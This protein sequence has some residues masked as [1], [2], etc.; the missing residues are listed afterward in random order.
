MNGSRLSFWCLDNEDIELKKSKF[1][2][3]EALFIRHREI[4][5]FHS[6][7]EIDIRLTRAEI[8][9][10]GYSKSDDKRLTVI[11]PTSDWVVV[12]F[13]RADDLP[14]VHEIIETAAKLNAAQII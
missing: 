5:H 8:R 12:K 2:S 7:Q 13:K 14:L 4:A 1:S 10:R 11:S 3:A 6:A 9:R